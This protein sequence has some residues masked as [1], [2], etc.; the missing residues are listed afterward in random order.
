MKSKFKIALIFIFFITSISFS[1]LL[2]YG[3]INGSKLSVNN[4]VDF[5]S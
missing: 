2:V 5:K 3:I 4:I 1:T